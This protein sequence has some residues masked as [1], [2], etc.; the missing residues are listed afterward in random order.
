LGGAD[1]VKNRLLQ[2]Q[3]LLASLGSLVE[4]SVLVTACVLLMA[5]SA[6]LLLQVLFRYILQKPLPWSEEVARFGL[7]WLGMLSAT[8]TARRGLHFL[9][10]WGTLA[11]PAVGRAWLRQMVNLLVI[12]FLSLI[13]W[14]SLAY[15]DIGRIQ[16]APATGVDMRFPYAAVT[17]GVGLLIV[18]FV[19]EIVDSLC[20]VM[21]GQRFSE[22]E[23]EELR[24]Y[25]LLT[26]R[27]GSSHS[28]AEAEHEG[29]S[30]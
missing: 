22:R 14:G 16:T 26:Q 19:L 21:T 17:V 3:Q 25:A 24:I 13:F 11:I 23:Q 29:R 1:R 30:P 6:I 4:A 9:F 28:S 18:T 5:L 8:L 10:R 15:L 7:V 2:F 20:G 12:G 27:G